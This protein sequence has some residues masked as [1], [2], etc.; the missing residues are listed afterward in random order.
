MLSQI[1]RFHSTLWLSN[2]P[3]YVYHI[4]F[5]CL[6]VIG[7]LGCLSILAIIN[8]TVNIFILISTFFLL[9][10]VNVCQ[11][12]FGKN[13]FFFFHFRVLHFPLFQVSDTCYS[14]S[15][16]NSCAISS[17]MIKELIVFQIYIESKHCWL[18]Q[19]YCHN[20]QSHLICWAQ[21]YSSL[22][23]FLTSSSS[24]SP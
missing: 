5:I 8:N 20:L 22:I 6:S 16:T 9:C 23:C 18:F 1:A 4:F 15:C 13:F 10:V 24:Y 7:H 11:S 21:G 17:E 19:L 12:A 14:G 3:L 2:I